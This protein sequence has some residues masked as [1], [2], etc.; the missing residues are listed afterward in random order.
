MFSFPLASSERELRLNFASQ[1]GQWSPAK[2]LFG[3]NR[4]SQSP[5]LTPEPRQTF[6]FP[7]QTPGNGPETHRSQPSGYPFKTNDGC[8][9][10]SRRVRGSSY[11]W[12]CHW[13]GCSKM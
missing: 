9:I 2:H 5:T 13:G 6:Q 7:D 12:T 3:L 10:L 4:A 1:L 8:P 11:L